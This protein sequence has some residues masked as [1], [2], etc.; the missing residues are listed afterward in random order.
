MAIKTAYLL[1][2]AQVCLSTSAAVPHVSTSSKGHTHQNGNLPNVTIFGTG[3]KIASKGTSNTQTTNYKVRV[4]IEALVEA[5]P[6]L[7]YISNV[8]GLQVSN[9]D[10][11]SINSTILLD[12]ARY[13]NADMENLISH[14]SVVT[15]GTDTLEETAFFLD[16]TVETHKP[17]VITGAMRPSTAITADGPLNLYQAVKFAGSDEAR[18]RGVLVVLNEKVNGSHS[19]PRS[20]LTSVISR[21]GSAYTTTKNN[22]NSLDTFYATEQGQVDFFIGQVDFF[23]GQVDFFIDQVPKF[24]SSP[25]TLATSHTSASGRQTFC[26]K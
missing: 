14:G 22:A 6:E 24:Y 11:G 9:V 13:V 1:L 17:V 3:G 20:I 16:L 19:V 21:I 15:H 2:L 12:L 8:S 23:I 10:S 7:C 25:S 18:D 26:P 5:V 4:T